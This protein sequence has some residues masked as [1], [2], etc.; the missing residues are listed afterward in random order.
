MWDL[1]E[2]S[3]SIRL[4]E[5]FLAADKPVALVCHAPGVLRHVKRPDG[6]PLVFG[7]DQADGFGFIRGPQV[8]LLEG[9]TVEG[10]IDAVAANKETVSIA[11]HLVSP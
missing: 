6:K 2:D 7:R 9:L 4:I 5:S 10:V 3:N 8:R 1:A 11:G